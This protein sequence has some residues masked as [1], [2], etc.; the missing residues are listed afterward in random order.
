MYNYRSIVTAD[1]ASDAE[2][3]GREEANKHTNEDNLPNL[4]WDIGTLETKISNLSE[5]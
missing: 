2:E 4:N 5:M 1:S 3:K